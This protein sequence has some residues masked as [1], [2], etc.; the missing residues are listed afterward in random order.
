[1]NLSLNMHLNMFFKHIQT[2][3]TQQNN[4]KNEQFYLL[5]FSRHGGLIIFKCFFKSLCILKC[6]VS[7]LLCTVKD[8]FYIFI[9]KKKLS[10]PG[11]TWKQ[12]QRRTS[13]FAQHCLGVQFLSECVQ[14]HSEILHNNIT[15]NCCFLATLCPQLYC[16][17]R[18]KQATLEP[19]KRWHPGNC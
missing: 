14:L 19:R 6:L 11:N 9:N 18:Q 15:V 1:M 5:I 16:P 10:L 8:V 2:R 7:L 12:W 13:P 3:K 17:W 4:Y